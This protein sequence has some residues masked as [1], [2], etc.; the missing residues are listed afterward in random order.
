MTIAEVIE[1][2]TAKTNADEVRWSLDLERVNGIFQTAYSDSHFACHTNE[3][4]FEVDGS[5][6]DTSK[7]EDMRRVKMLAIAIRQQDIRRITGMS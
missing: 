5:K 7:Q 1:D 3:P 4:W 6:V 2:L